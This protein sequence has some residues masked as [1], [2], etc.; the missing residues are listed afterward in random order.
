MI[1]AGKGICTPESPRLCDGLS[2]PP[3]KKFLGA[4]EDPT[5]RKS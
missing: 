1:L 4:P 2:Y 5:S 3:E